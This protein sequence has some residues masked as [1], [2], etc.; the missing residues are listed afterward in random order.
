MDKFPKLPPIDLSGARAVHAEVM[1][2]MRV[3]REFALK[4]GTPKQTEDAKPRQPKQ[5][6]PLR[7]MTFMEYVGQ[8]AS[9]QRLKAAIA[10]SRNYGKTLPKVEQVKTS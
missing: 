8:E 4:Y 3:E 1:R 5:F 7:P 6:L 2:Q 10:A 9:V